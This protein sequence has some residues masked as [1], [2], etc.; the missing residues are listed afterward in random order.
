[1]ILQTISQ[2]GADIAGAQ[3]VHANV[4]ATQPV[5]RFATE[6]QRKRMLPRLISGEFKASFG[7]TEP[8]SGAPYNASSMIKAIFQ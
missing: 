1:M 4:Y 7:V 2:S 5:A 8:R 6:E 3:S